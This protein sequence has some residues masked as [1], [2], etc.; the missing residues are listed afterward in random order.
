MHCGAAA[1]GFSLGLNGAIIGLGLGLGWGWGC[2]DL[3]PQSTV[4]GDRVVFQRQTQAGHAH[5]PI[6]HVPRSDPT[7]SHGTI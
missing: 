4:A 1:A 6:Q 3:V 5:Q 7:P 2:V